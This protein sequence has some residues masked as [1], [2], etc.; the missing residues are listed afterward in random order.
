MKKGF[1]LIELLVVVAIIGILATI[2]ISSVNNARD[3]AKYSSL[4]SQYDQI[5]KGLY[6][7]VLEENLGDYWTEGEL[8]SGS[9]PTMSTLLAINSGAGS[10]ISNYLSDN[11]AIAIGGGDIIYDNDANPYTGCGD[12]IL[13]GVNLTVFRSESSFTTEDLEGIDLFIDTEDDPECG[14]FT[15]N[16]AGYI[17]RLNSRL[18]F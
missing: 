7:A 17:Y 16:G 4:L 12:S 14:Q 5:E 3:R 15:Y 11:V 8:A 9:N 6:A 1:T 18:A 2:V 13:S 10:S